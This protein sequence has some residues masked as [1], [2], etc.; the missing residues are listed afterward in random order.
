MERLTCPPIPS[1]IEL[2]Q[3]FSY[4]TSQGRHFRQYIRA[5]N[6]VFSF[7]SMGVNVDEHFASARSGVYTFRAQGAIYHQIESLLPLLP[8]A[9]TRPRFFTDLYI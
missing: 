1:P 2:L 5:Y 3:L 7:T 6:H 9:G 8:A 4:E